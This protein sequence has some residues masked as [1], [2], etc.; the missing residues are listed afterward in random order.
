MLEMKYIDIKRILS[1]ALLACLLVI[2]V[3]SQE[4][5][6]LIDK[7]TNPAAAVGFD[8]EPGAIE[9]V[10]SLATEIWYFLCCVLMVFIHVG[11]MAYEGGAVRSKNVLATMMK[12]L[13]TICSVG[14]AFFLIGWWIYM[15]LYDWPFSFDSKGAASGAPWSTLMGTHLGDSITPL[16][17]WAFALFAMTTAS[18]LSGACVERI[19]M[20]AYIFFTIIL[21][22]ILWTVAAAWGWHPSGWWL[23]KW[24]FH[25]FGCA[26]VVHG[27]AGFFTLGVLFNLG[28]RKGKYKDGKPRPILPHNLPLTMLGLWLIYAGFF[29]FLGA[30]VILGPGSIFEVTAFGMPMTIAGLT[31]NIFMSMIGGFFGSYVGSKGDTFFTMSGGL[32]GIIG[33]SAGMDLY[34]PM[35]TLLLAFGV[36]VAMPYV[37]SFLERVVKVDD[38]VGAVAVHGFSGLV[39]VPLAGIF[40]AGYPNAGGAPA[41]NLMGQLAGTVIACGL[42]GFLPG[43]GISYLLKKLNLLRVDEEVEDAGLDVTELGVP[44][45]PERDIISSTTY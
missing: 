45:Y 32:A 43:W 23:T 38:A 28:P 42:L 25:D 41:I 1:I 12:N 17:V 35:L 27:L 22:G 39:S 13:L 9:W 44:G 37:A 6:N 10:A 14:L 7:E 26:V 16:F 3:F 2:G 15:A 5:T 21:G 8:M 31:A 34:S 40:L 20:G 36:G 11:F 4:E 19:K 29:G 33:T 24:G 30:C 18:I